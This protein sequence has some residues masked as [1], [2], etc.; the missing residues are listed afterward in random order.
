VAALPSI[1][2]NDL[3]RVEEVEDGA[4][5]AGEIF[6]QAFGDELPGFSSHLVAFYQA[7]RNCFVVVGYV[8]CTVR[9]DLCFCGGLVLD[10]R[11]IRRMPASHQTA[12]RSSG[13]VG[14]RLLDE[15]SRRFAQLPALW[16]MVG[17]EPMRETFHSAKFEAAPAPNLMVR[18]HADSGDSA[19]AEV[20]RRVI[21]VGS[22]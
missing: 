8:H 2:A 18:W 17:D 19:R 1:P 14:R 20:L 6:R 10:E 9:D 21:D 13:G 7:A 3:I 16:A 4:F 12:L 15:A 5:F 22:F 11:A